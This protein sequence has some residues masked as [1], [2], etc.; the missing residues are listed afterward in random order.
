MD[1]INILGVGFDA[2]TKEEALARCMAIVGSQKGYVAT[3]NPEIICRCRRDK[4]A[5]EAVNG[6]S[7]VVPDG[8]GVI[9]ASRILG[10]PIKNRVPG[11]DLAS[12]VMSEL[13]KQGKTLFLLGAKPGVA[14]DAAEKLALLYPELNIVGTN[15]GYFKDDAPVIDKINAV[16]PDVLFVCLGSPRQ[17]QWT[18]D[19]IDKLNVSLCMCLGGSLDV[20]SGNV[21]RAPKMFRKLGL[22]WFYRLLKEPKRIGRMAVL[23]KFILLAVK[24]RMCPKCSK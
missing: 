11:I 7:L 12:D 9:Y 21:E 22:E 20:F 16:S 6:A 3:P 19:N 18:K 23:P 17:E 8:I 1:R 4:S 13:E 10:T 24:E 15:D 2:V 5:S 14:E